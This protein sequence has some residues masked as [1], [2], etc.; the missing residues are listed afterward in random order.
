MYAC[1]TRFTSGI[2]AG[3]L[4]R[5]RHG[6]A[7]A[8]VVD[9]LRAGLFLQDELGEQRGHEVA[10]DELAGVVDEEAAVGVAVEGH[11][12]VGVLLDRHAHDELA[13]LGQERVRLVVRE[14]AVGLEVAAHDLD[15]GQPL[16]H[17]RE[18]HAGHAV[19]RV[20]HD[21]ERL[22]RARVDEREH[23]L[24]ELLP[25][26]VRLRPVPGS[27][28]GACPK[29]QRA[30]ADVEQA[31]LAADRQRPAADDLHARVVLR[32]VRG[33]DGDA[34]VE[35]ELADREI[36]HLGADEPELEHVGACLGRAADDGLGHRRRRDAHVVP[37]GD[38]LRLEHLD[39][40]AADRVGT[41]LVELRG[42]DPAHV[43][44]LENLRVEHEVGC[45]SGRK[46]P[47]PAVV[48]TAGMERKLATVLFVD[49]VDSTALVTGSDPEVVRRRV[50]TFFE[51]VSHCVI[52]HGGIV[53]KFAGDAVMAAFGIPQAHED[54]AERAVRAGLAIMDAVDELELEARAGIESGEV[55][56]DDSESTFATGEAVTLAA[57]LQQAGEPGQLLIGPAAHR[58]TLGKVE[59][60]DV[61]P[62]DLKG[63]DRADLG[64]AGA[65]H[66]R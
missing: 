14:G 32:V 46:K 23:A 11:A 30:V 65:E 38:P 55:V 16:Q 54:D 52:T 45:Y 49:L 31:R 39:E 44:G 63:L 27:D 25:D 33:G 1:P 4:D 19:R 21:R 2:A 42:V 62:V 66:E 15:L 10:G 12:E 50:Q 47:A 26:V 35:P 64:V 61:G 51:R 36:D 22:D 13:V 43:V 20:G 58:L 34:A 40:G 3:A 5:L 57:R 6:P 9:D 24:D 7:R 56:A 41:L 48:Y 37:D 17:R 53:E 29:G 8:H 60:E 59:V 28:P 18:H